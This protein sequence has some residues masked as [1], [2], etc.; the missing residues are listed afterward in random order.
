M[1]ENKK[2][3]EI[4][5]EAKIFREIKNKGRDESKIHDL[6]D[7]LLDS[8][9]TLEVFLKEL[10]QIVNSSVSDEQIKADSKK[11][12]NSIVNELNVT[13]INIKDKLSSIY[14]ESEEE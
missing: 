12:V 4:N 14:K 6:K 10:L 2:W 13:K 9:N 5:D 1:N 8:V 11:M 7:S 3:S